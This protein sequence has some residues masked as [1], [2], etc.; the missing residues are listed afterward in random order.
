VNQSSAAPLLGENTPIHHKTRAFGRATVIVRAISF[1][2]LAAAAWSLQRIF[3]QSRSYEYTARSG[4]FATSERT[5]KTVHN[6]L[7]LMGFLHLF[8]LRFYF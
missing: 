7:F 2:L 6:S 5:F 3:L 4:F 1:L 8:D